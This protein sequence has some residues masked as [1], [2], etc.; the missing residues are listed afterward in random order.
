MIAAP[1]IL[2]A[3]FIPFAREFARPDELIARQAITRLALGPHARCALALSGENPLTEADYHNFEMIF[4][5]DESYHKVRDMM[6]IEPRRAT[7]LRPWNHARKRYQKALS[8][9]HRQLVPDSEGPTSPFTADDDSPLSA[10]P[11]VP[12]P[13]H[14]LDAREYVTMRG[15]RSALR[16]AALHAFHLEHAFDNG[17]PYPRYEDPPVHRV[18]AMRAA[19][20]FRDDP[21]KLR[22]ASALL[23]WHVPLIRMSA[24]GEPDGS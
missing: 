6:N 13:S 4:S 2:W 14:W 23:G 17:V 11:E 16:A 18:I 22:R 20:H 19:F 7:D 24:G 9:R 12:P 21:R 5:G 3:L 10:G 1:E 8:E 15:F